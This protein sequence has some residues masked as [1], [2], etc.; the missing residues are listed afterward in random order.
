MHL[1]AHTWSSFF[2][3]VKFYQLK[4]G[5]EE[6]ATTLTKIINKSIADGIFPE[7]WK[8]AIITP[9]IKKGCKEDKSV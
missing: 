7:G 1:F 4:L 8:K 9:V 3:D 5:A 6:I 2:D